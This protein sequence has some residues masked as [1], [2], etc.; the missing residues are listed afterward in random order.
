MSIAA[1][2]SRTSGVHKQ[3]FGY[4]RSLAKRFPFAIYHRL[5]GDE[6]QVWRVLVQ[7]TRQASISPPPPAP[8]CC[9]SP[10]AARS[11]NARQSRRECG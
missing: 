4:Y 3:H 11:S 1:A 9:R 2:A 5:D 8:P 6:I 7:D 10:A